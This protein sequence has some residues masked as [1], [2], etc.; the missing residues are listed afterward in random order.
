MP[1]TKLEL[2]IFGKTDVGMV[3]EGNED[4]FI[5]LSDDTAPGLSNALLIV[6]DGMGGHLAG[7]V[8]SAMAVER[9][10]EDL[11]VNLPDE[12]VDIE[13]VFKS[14]V[15][16]ANGAINEGSKKPET[17]GMA[18]TFTG[19][20]LIGHFAVF[21]H[22]GDSRAYLCRGGRTAQITKDHS[23]V[24][25][26]VEMGT[27]T[28]E[29]AEQHPQRNVITRAVGINPEV[30]VDTGQLE[31]MPDDILVF[32]SDGLTSYVDAKEINKIC[33]GYA[34]N[35]ACSDLIEK[36][37][38]RGGHDN[39]TVIVAKITEIKIGNLSEIQ[40]RLTNQFQNLRDLTPKI[41][42]GDRVRKLFGRN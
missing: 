25:E 18:T 14:A 29:E 17:S 4:S 6:A 11:K 34:P 31:L 3:R 32:C 23:W 1:R 16:S 10:V 42:L 33:A 28:E 35:E 26:Q 20:L 38:A 2:S 9:V 22:V 40:E 21:A 15:Q 12:S 13:T 8:A 36:A 39:I 27:M 19:A 30:H 7:E 5:T 24:A 41:P 37:K